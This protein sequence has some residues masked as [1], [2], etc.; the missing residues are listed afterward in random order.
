MTLA[1]FRIYSRSFSF[2]SRRCLNVIVFQKIAPL[3]TNIPFLHILE[4]AFKKKKNRAQ[5]VFKKHNYMLR[6]NKSIK[7]LILLVSR[8]KQVQ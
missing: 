7:L 4:G 6:S 5:A 2:A 8:K 1:Q 3:E